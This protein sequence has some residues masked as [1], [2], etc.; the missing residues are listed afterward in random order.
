MTVIA[1]HQR[2]RADW[3]PDIG[4]GSLL[5]HS[6]LILKPN[7]D[8]RRR[9]GSKQR[10]FHHVGK[11]FFKSRLGSRIFLRMHR[12]RLQPGQLE[13]MQPFA[14]RAFVH[15]DR[16]PALDHG[17]Q[18]DTPPAHHFVDCRVRSLDHQVV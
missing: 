2:P 16:K 10:R 15:F 11:S 5:T 18:V 6:G 1:H 17:Q 12:P 3:R 9:R 4:V 8:R 7:L 14:N 13:L